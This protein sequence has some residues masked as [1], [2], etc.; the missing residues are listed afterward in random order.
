[1]IVATESQSEQDSFRSQ[2][3]DPSDRAQT[4]REPDHRPLC[5]QELSGIPVRLS[6]FHTLSLCLTSLPSL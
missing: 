5:L 6:L 1:M 3:S 2:H 4:I